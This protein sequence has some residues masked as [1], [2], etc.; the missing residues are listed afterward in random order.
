MSSS[1]GE[2]Q[3]FGPLHMTLP[4]TLVQVRMLVG[5]RC[6]IQLLALINSNTWNIVTI[7]DGETKLVYEAYLTASGATLHEVDNTEV[8]TAK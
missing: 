2:T 4:N 7:L 6:S 8:D 3:S 1:T 5:I